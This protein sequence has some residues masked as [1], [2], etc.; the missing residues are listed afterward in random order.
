MSKIPLSTFPQ[1]PPRTLTAAFAKAA[2]VAAVTET[3]NGVRERNAAGYIGWPPARLVARLR[4]RTPAR[5]LLASD[6]ADDAQAQRPDIDNA[7][8]CSPVR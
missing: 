1:V 8:R 4:G 5:K 6:P 3:L 7:I 2:G